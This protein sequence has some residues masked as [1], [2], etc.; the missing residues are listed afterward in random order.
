M[1]LLEPLS[2][3]KTAQGHALIH[4]IFFLTMFFIDIDIDKSTHVANKTAHNTLNVNA[5]FEVEDEGIQELNVQNMTQDEEK[6]EGMIFMEES[7]AKA[8]RQAEKER[9][10]HAFRLLKWGHFLTFCT[11]QFIFIMKH[12]NYYNLTQLL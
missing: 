3:V 10:L 6:Y 4:L 9:E 2:G 8:K 1:R 11:Q 5:D 7:D 12:K